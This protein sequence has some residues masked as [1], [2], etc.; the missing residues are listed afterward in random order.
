MSL[1]FPMRSDASGGGENIQTVPV[2]RIG[3][4]EPVQMRSYSRKFAPAPTAKIV[5]LG[6]TRYRRGVDRNQRF[7]LPWLSTYTRWLS[8]RATAQ[9]GVRCR[10]EIVARVDKIHRRKIE[11]TVSLP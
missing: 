10:P 7:R 8:T 6:R 3:D 5:W 2:G 1:G 11:S 9:T 4:V